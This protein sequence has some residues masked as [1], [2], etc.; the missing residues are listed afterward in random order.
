M[1]QIFK[2]HKEIS[3][4]IYKY[5]SRGSFVVE[6]DRDGNTLHARFK[7]R[8]AHLLVRDNEGGIGA[9]KH[10]RGG[11]QEDGCEEEEDERS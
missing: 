7:S 1:L 2:Y 4:Q 6:V 8:E 3:T 11:D 5:N 10:H 9:R